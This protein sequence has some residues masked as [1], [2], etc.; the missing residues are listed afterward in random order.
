MSSSKLYEIKDKNHVWLNDKVIYKMFDKE[1]YNEILKVTKKINEKYLKK[2]GKI[3]YHIS[4]GNLTMKYMYHVPFVMKFI[5]YF[6]K[7]FPNAEIYINL[8]D[9]SPLVH[10]MY[11][12]VKPCINEQTLHKLKIHD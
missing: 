7:D 11:N 5:N 6:E 9:F 2:Y 10:T 12:I 3:H 1:K 8:Y 4:M